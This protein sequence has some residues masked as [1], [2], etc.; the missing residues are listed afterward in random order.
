M[1]SAYMTVGGFDYYP[2]TNANLSGV[3]FFYLLASL[4]LM[5][6]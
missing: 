1:L 5:L 3:R 6:G 4:G 2:S